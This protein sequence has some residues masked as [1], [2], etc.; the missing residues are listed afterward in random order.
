MLYRKVLL[1]DLTACYEA[2]VAQN[3]AGSQ[4]DSFQV[5]NVLDLSLGGHFFQLQ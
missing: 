4:S 1:Q 5:G 3:L 2:P